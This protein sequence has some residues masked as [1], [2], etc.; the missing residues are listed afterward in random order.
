MKKNAWKAAAAAAVLLVLPVAATFAQRAALSVDTYPLAQGL[1]TTDD[2]TDYS[3]FR[4]G[5]TFEYLVGSKYSIGVRGDYRSSE[6][7]KNYTITFF[8]VG[9]HGRVYPMDSGLKKF[10]LDFGLGYSSFENEPNSGKTTTNDGLAWD[11]TAGWKQVLTANLFAEASIGWSLVKS[12]AIGTYNSGW[13]PGLSIG[14][15]F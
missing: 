15:L 5:A 9:L 14:V 2:D 4:I 8:G 1:I 13:I 7:E 10:F 3:D 6:Q 12:R 11:L